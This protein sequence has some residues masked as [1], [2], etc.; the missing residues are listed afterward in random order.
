M[1]LI[2][3]EKG[4]PW[5]G[6]NPHEANPIRLGEGDP[7]EANPFVEERG[8][9]LS[10]SIHLEKGTPLKQIPFA[11]ERGGNPLGRIPSTW[12]RGPL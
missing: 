2:H 6:G 7:H 3:L 11:V 10:E 12:R 4:T 9:P 5:I 1:N 8:K